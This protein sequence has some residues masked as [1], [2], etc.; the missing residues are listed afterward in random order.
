VIC[1]S[2]ARKMANYCSIG[3]DARIGLGF[4]R[5]RSTNRIVNKMIYAWEGIKKF[6]RPSMNMHNIIEKNGEYGKL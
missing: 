3:V 5:S 4:D 2:F 1:S 6:I